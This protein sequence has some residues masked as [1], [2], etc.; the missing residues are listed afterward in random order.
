MAGARK[1]D[2]SCGR[3]LHSSR[4]LPM[5]TWSCQMAVLEVGPIGGPVPY[6]APEHM[7]GWWINHRSASTGTRRAFV[8]NAS[9]GF[10]GGARAS[11]AI[12]PYHLAIGFDHTRDRSGL[13]STR[14]LPRTPSVLLPRWADDTRGVRWGWSVRAGCEGRVPVQGKGLAP[15]SRDQTAEDSQRYRRVSGWPSSEC[16][17]FRNEHAP[18]G[19]IHVGE[20]R[21]PAKGPSRVGHPQ[22]R[23]EP[24][25]NDYVGRRVLPGAQGRNRRLAR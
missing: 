20:D 15:D 11:H 3:R 5:P 24:V 7:S 19:V 18:V 14:A 6:H 1:R 4:L 9:S 21:P 22:E 10:V 23:S 16:D 17:S 25:L 13:C 8:A 12:S 2:L